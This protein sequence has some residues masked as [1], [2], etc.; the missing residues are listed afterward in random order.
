MQHI[1][2]VG[3]R[4]ALGTSIT[5]PMEMLNAADLIQRITGVGAPRLQMQLVGVEAGNISLNAGLELVCNNTLNDI[6]KT[7]LIIL[8]ALWGNPSGICKQHPALL[9]WLRTHHENETRIRAVGTGSF[10]LAQFC[11]LL[12]CIN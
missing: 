11:F 10:F 9:E 1:T 5:I 2:I 12:G 8:P 4:K 6:V 3:F 7:D